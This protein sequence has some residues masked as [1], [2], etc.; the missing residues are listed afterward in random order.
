MMYEQKIDEEFDLK[1]KIH[2][3]EDKLLRSKDYTEQEKL[4]VLLMKMRMDLQKLQWKKTE[5]GS[6]C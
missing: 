5:R 4:R 2:R 6:Y 1:C 3:F